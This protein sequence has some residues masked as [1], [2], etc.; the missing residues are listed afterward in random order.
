MMRA[1]ASGRARA[2]VADMAEVIKTLLQVRG[3]FAFTD[4]FRWGRAFG[5]QVVNRP[6]PVY[7]GGGIRIFDDQKPKMLWYDWLR[8]SSG[9]W[10]RRRR[11]PLNCS[12]LRKR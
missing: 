3:H 9:S 4:T 6:M 2:V 11:T 1:V 10:S 12:G 8:W 7:P 5:R